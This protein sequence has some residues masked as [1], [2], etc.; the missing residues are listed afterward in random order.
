MITMIVKLPELQNKTIGVFRREFVP[1]I[2]E[3]LWIEQAD[4]VGGEPIQW[5][6]YVENVITMLAIGSNG[7]DVPAVNETVEIRVSEFPPESQSSDYGVLWEDETNVPEWAKT[8]TMHIFASEP[9]RAGEVIEISLCELDAADPQ[10]DLTA[11]IKEVVRCGSADR[12]HGPTE[13]QLFDD[14][15][16][17]EL[18][19]WQSN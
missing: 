15:L 12:Q 1:R 9:F 8:D 11:R 5:R 13:V 18:I 4:A 14:F 6:Y 17:L 7:E 19:P 10:P 16:R 2:G 3:I